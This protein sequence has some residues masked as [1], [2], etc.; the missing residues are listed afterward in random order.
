MSV[1]HKSDIS[2]P[3]VGP[4]QLEPCD[5]DRKHD[6]ITRH[7]AQTASVHHSLL[8]FSWFPYHEFSPFM[9]IQRQSV[10]FAPR[11]DDRPKLLEQTKGRDG[12]WDGHDLITLSKLSQ[13]RG[14]LV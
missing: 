9:L 11:P 6:G 10:P 2:Y 4:F 14:W 1:E 7:L 8:R 5:V 13:I 3:V 12:E